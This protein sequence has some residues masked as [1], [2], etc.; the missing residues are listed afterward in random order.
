MPRPTTNTAPQRVIRNSSAGVDVA[1]NL[2]AARPVAP[3]TIPTP[4]FLGVGVK[5]YKPLAAGIP[6]PESLGVRPPR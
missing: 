3:V 1:P 6:A 5:T 4:E 2:Q